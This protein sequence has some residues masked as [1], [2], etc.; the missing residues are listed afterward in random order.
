ML[1]L[2]GLEFC[3]SEAVAPVQLLGAIGA[4]CDVLDSLLD[5]KPSER[6]PTSFVAPDGAV[7]VLLGA[8]L[9][10]SKA[11]RRFKPLGPSPDH[12][13]RATQQPDLEDV[14]DGHR[15]LEQDGPFAVWN[16]T[17]SLA[18]FSWSNWITMSVP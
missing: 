7:L 4:A 8:Q 1:F 13:G 6:H 14:A 3:K 11:L 17:F 5:P 10:A 15:L 12:V 9:A 2:T 18:I 16:I